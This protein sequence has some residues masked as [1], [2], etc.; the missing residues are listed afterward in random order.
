MKLHIL[1]TMLGVGGL[2]PRW[3]TLERGIVAGMVY[4]MPFPYPD[5]MSG[6]FFIIAE[7]MVMVQTTGLTGFCMPQWQC[8]SPLST[9]D[10]ADFYTHR[11]CP[12]GT[13]RFFSGP[14]LA[15]PEGRTNTY[16]WNNYEKVY[17]Q[18]LIDSD[19]MSAQK[20]V[21]FDLIIVQRFSSSSGGKAPY[22]FEE[23][24]INLLESLRS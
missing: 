23:S 10:H 21:P 6:Y 19:N 15:D 11:D 22:M 1:S 8:I 20:A 3:Q 13:N 4:A 18:E 5:N 24:N 2:S 9:D 7:L 17:E 14:Y 12:N 16:L